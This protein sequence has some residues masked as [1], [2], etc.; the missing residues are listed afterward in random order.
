MGDKVMST[1]PT[2]DDSMNAAR[3][4]QETIYSDASLR[5]DNGHVATRIG[6]HFGSVVQEDQ[7]VFGSASPSAGPSACR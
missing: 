4:M 3:R 2:A 5:Y 7:D 6:C 1:F